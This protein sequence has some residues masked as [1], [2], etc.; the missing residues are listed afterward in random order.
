MHKIRASI[1]ADPSTTQF[2][3]SISHSRSRNAGQ[4]DIN[5]FRLHVKA[6]LGCTRVRASMSQ[7]LIAP[8]GAVSANHIDF[9]ATIV[10]GSSQVMKQVE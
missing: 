3:S 4:P 2:Q 10:N 7:K 1:I 8:R 9:A 6:M 5:R